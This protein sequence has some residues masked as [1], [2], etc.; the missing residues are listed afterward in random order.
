[1]GKPRHRASVVCE[2]EEHLLLVRLRDP[3]TKAVSFYP[4][5]GGIEPGESPA[6]A[7]DR[8]ERREVDRNVGEGHA[9]ESPARTDA[10]R[11]RG[12]QRQPH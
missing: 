12:H 4:P 9:R 6:D 7:K 5:G 10:E 1:M 2:T 11:R 8:R 3:T